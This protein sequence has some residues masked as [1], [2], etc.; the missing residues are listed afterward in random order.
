MVDFLPRFDA[1]VSTLFTDLDQRGLLD[2]VLVLVAGDFGRTPRLNAG[3][4]RG[5]G[6]DHWPGAVSCLLGGGGIQGGRIIGATTPHGEMPAE[7]PLIPGDL[8][9]TIYHVL[10]ISPDVSF[11]NYSGRPIPILERGEVISELL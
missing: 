5:P 9:A 7:R 4:A 6:R 10:G 3:D 2:R 8:H 1:A 11:K